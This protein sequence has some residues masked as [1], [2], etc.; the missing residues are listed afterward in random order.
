MSSKASRIPTAK[1]RL[2]KLSID[3]RDLQAINRNRNTPRP[4]A[5][6][7]TAGSSA[8][9]STGGGTG[10]FLDIGGGTMVGPLAILF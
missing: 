8:A 3:I 9:G 2:R 10:N 1:D 6:T 4:V 5:T 7:A